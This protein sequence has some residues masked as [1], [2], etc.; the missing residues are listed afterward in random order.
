M[1]AVDVKQLLNSAVAVMNPVCAKHSNTLKIIN[2]CESRIKGNFELLLQVLIN[3]I[4]NASKHTREGV[5]CVTTSENTTNAVFTVQDNGQGIASDAVPHIFEKGYTTGGETGSD[6]QYARKPWSCTVGFSNSY[7][8]ARREPS[9]D[10][11][12]QSLKRESLLYY[13]NEVLV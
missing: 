12:Y 8:P 13:Q 11:V 1:T 5:I 7:P 10:S 2:G 9:S 3:L 6:L 4:V